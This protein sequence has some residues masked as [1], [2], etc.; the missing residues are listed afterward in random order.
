MVLLQLLK[1]GIVIQKSDWATWKSHAYRLII[2]N[3]PNN[4]LHAKDL[5]KQIHTNKGLYKYKIQIR[6]ISVG[7]AITGTFVMSNRS[8]EVGEDK[9]Y[10]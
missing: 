1:V 2:K 5:N 7:K 6:R 9:K 8:F 10:N 3:Q 4:T